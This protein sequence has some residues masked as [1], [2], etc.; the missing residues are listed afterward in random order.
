MGANEVITI[1]EI[2]DDYERFRSGKGV[3]ELHDYMTDELIL[4]VIKK[5]L[6]KADGAPFTVKMI[7]TGWPVW[8]EVGDTQKQAD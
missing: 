4:R 5:A 6:K 2:D 3:V 8:C 1:N 7:N